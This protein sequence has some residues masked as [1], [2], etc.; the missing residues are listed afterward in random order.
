MSPEQDLSDD[1][2]DEQDAAGEQRVADDGRCD[3][4]EFPAGAGDVLRA[5]ETSRVDQTGAGTHRS[6]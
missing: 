3:G 2:E 4:V 5:A 1:D 6:R